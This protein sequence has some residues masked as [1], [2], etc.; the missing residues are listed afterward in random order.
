MLVGQLADGL[1]RS[2]EALG[3]YLRLRLS[4][5]AHLHCRVD[6]VHGAV[7]SVAI[8]R[9]CLRPLLELISGPKHAP[10]PIVS[11]RHQFFVCAAPGEV[12]GSKHF[13]STKAWVLTLSLV[14]VG[15]VFKWI[16]ILL[17][18]T[19][20]LT[21]WVLGVLCQKRRHFVVAFVLEITLC[22]V[23]LLQVVLCLHCTS[24]ISHLV[25]CDERMRP[26][27]ERIQIIG[28]FWFGVLHLKW[29]HSRS[30]FLFTAPPKRFTRPIVKE[31]YALLRVKG[32]HLVWKAVIWGRRGWLKV[33]LACWT[34]SVVLQ[35][36][37]HLWKTVVGWANVCLILS[38]SL[39][40][41]F[42]IGVAK[43]R[44]FVHLLAFVLSASYAEA[45]SL[46]YFCHAGG[47]DDLSVWISL[48]HSICDRLA[49]IA[50]TVLGINGF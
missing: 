35:L 42:K 29:G 36:W 8:L 40:W 39:L 21:C 50:R 26:G 28:A 16:P 14:Q 44:H 5:L 41:V 49:L 30:V 7:C 27:S 2:L 47:F 23:W 46:F 33:F 3:N 34:S 45:I 6:W 48:E 1:Q 18:R 25:Q 10:G 31:E 22:S 37:E 19:S 15:R 24:A 43:Q 4:V 11:H 13:T 32:F 17:C 20:N 9:R 12:R 38:V